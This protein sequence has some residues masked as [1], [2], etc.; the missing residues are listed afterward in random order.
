MDEKII[1]NTSLESLVIQPKND[2]PSSVNKRNEAQAQTAILNFLTELGV[3]KIIY[4]DDRCSINELKEVYIGKLKSHYI[5]KP[6]EIEFVD[7]K[8]PASPFEKEIN[9]IWDGATDEVKREMYLKILTFENNIEELDNSVAPLKLKSVLKEKIDLLSPTEW[10][11]TKDTI[12]QSL[13]ES[14][15]ILF[16]FDIEFSFAPLADNRDGRDLAAEILHNKLISKFVYC[17]IFSHLFNISEEY[18]KRSE[19]CKSHELEKEKFYTISKKRFQ[20]DSYL[21]G[22]AE[23]IRNT[24]LINEVELL[25]KKGT[26]ILRKSY[27]QSIKEINRLT[28]ES[29]NHIIQKSSIGEGVWEMATLIRV[30]NI[31]TT[32]KALESLLPDSSRIEINQSL[33][34]IR[35]VERLKTGGETPFEKSQ[36]LDLRMNELFVQSNIQNQLHYP[37]SNGDVFKIEDKVYILLVQPCN[38]A[39]R[40]NGSRDRKYNH[41]LLVEIEII[42]KSNFLKFKKGQLATLET[43]ED[44]SLPSDLIK[45]AR[46]STFQS[47]NLSP[48]DLTVYSKE[49]KAKIK[50]SESNIKSS[51]IQDSWKKRYQEIHKDFSDFAQGIKTFNK[52]RTTNKNIIKNSI[53]NGSVFS[54]YKINNETSLINRGKS[55]EFNIQRIA[56]YKSPYSDDLLQKFMQYLSRNAFEHDFTN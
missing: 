45:I 14:T 48:L 41:G 5:N 35:K 10:L 34:K 2:I 9:L 18:D 16:L 54:G 19:Y 37:L 21:P 38:I 46:F 22:L 17:G 12:L 55:L 50:L 25:K 26:E 15:K 20:S 4:V 39:M 23:G 3:Q 47:V 42:S 8:L 33:S 43:I 1:I 13:S 29:F 56:H 31:I 53:F 44:I 30:S 24:L 11:N 7:W 40:S 6:E 36:V 49:G 28:P 27:N 51:T 32:H 52:M